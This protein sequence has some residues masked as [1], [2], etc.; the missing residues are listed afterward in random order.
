MPA[1]TLGDLGAQ[2]ARLIVACRNCG[3][4]RSIA[5]QDLPAE[6]DRARRWTSLRF[7]CI[8][9]GSRDAL[10]GIDSDRQPQ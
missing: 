10:H 3:H 6:I 2:G 1:S 9:C 5:P 4:L 8:R 7:R